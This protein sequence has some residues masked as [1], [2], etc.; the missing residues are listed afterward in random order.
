MAIARPLED[1]IEA[2]DGEVCALRVWG[3]PKRLRES[4]PQAFGDGRQR[5]RAVRGVSG[6]GGR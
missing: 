6:K 2:G 4:V 5:Q 1:A 3:E